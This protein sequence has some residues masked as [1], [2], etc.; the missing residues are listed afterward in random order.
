MIRH[1]EIARHLRDGIAS[2]R[3]EPGSTIPPLPELMREYGVSRETARHAVTTL[4]SEGL[5]TPMQGVGTVVRDTSPVALA[6]RPERPSPLWTGY[7]ELIQT[8]WHDF[9]PEVSELF[10]S[11]DYLHRRRYQW[12]GRQV[13]Q[14]QD[15]WI[16]R[17]IVQAITDV[18]IVI[19]D[20]Q[21]PPEVDIFTAMTRANQQPATVTETVAARMPDPDE[22]GAL[23][24]PPG[25]PVV[26]VV[27]ITRGSDDKPLETSSFVGGSDRMSYTYQVPYRP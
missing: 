3:Y 11:D 9:D 27:R 7:D 16:P 19:D 18:G 23:S 21:T 1:M 14:T 8:S 22:A 5:V 2:G 24:V 26:I 17:S 13:A 4:A 10:G 12:Q 20:P 15:Q 6:Y 25:V